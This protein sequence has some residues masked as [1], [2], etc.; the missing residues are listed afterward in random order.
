[1]TSETETAPD[2]GC[3]FIIKAFDRSSLVG[4]ILILRIKILFLNTLRWAFRV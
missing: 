1:M 2:Y 3:R 4:N